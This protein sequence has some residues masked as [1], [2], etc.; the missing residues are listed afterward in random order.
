LVYK[1]LYI[2]T[3]SI[4]AKDS[5]PPKAHGIPSGYQ[6][7]NGVDIERCLL[8]EPNV[9]GGAGQSIRVQ[10]YVCMNMQIGVGLCS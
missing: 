1:V 5:D 10:Y 9:D 7:R 6:G 8:V 3:E 4:K 2:V